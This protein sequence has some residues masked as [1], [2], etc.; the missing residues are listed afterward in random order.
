MKLRLIPEMTAW[1]VVSA[2]PCCFMQCNGPDALMPRAPSNPHR[3]HSS[4][5]SCSDGLDIDAELFSLMAFETGYDCCTQEQ[6][7]DMASQQQ[8]NN[9]QQL[10]L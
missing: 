7:I 4:S 6:S 9:E 5:S 2:P 10:R 3:I 8:P 1:D